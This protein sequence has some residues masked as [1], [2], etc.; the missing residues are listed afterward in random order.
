MKPGQLD[1]SPR[2]SRNGPSAGSALSRFAV[3]PGSA[4]PPLRADLVKDFD[5]AVAREHYDYDPQDHQN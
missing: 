1:K 4:V 3:K 5:E 2:K